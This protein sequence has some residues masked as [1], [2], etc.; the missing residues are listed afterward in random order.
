MGTEN[1]VRARRQT[2]DVGGRQ[3]KRTTRSGVSRGSRVKMIAAGVGSAAIIAVA[4]FSYLYSSS[5]HVAVV[6][7]DDYI[8]EVAGEVSDA[9]VN[10]LSESTVR[11]MIDKCVVEQ[12]NQEEISKII[13]NAIDGGM[14]ATEVDNLAETIQTHLSKMDMD[15]S[16]L[17]SDAQKNYINTQAYNIANDVLSG[18]TLN[19]SFSDSDYSALANKVQQLVVRNIDFEKILSEQGYYGGSSATTVQNLV[20]TPAFESAL[21]DAI[22]SATAGSGIGGTAAVNN[23]QL[24][25]IKNEILRTVQAG[26]KNGRDGADGRQGAQGAQGLTGAAGK[27][28]KDGVTPTK[29]VDYFTQAEIAS[30]ESAAATKAG[31]VVNTKIQNV[32]NQ[33]TTNESSL[34]NLV[35]QVTN[36][37]TDVTNVTNKVTSAG[38]TSSDDIN[39]L[40]QSISS[41]NSNINAIESNANS[42]KNSVRVKKTSLSV[43][44]ADGSEKIVDTTGMAMADFVDLLAGNNGTFTNV[45][46]TYGNQITTIQAAI[47]D[48]DEIRT[49]IKTASVNIS[50]LT[51]GQRQLL[52]D[53]QDLDG[54]SQTLADGI[55]DVKAK[56]TALEQ[57]IA[58]GDSEAIKN[59]KDSLVY[60][61]AKIDATD[62]DLSSLGLSDEQL[63]AYRQAQNIIK[64]MKDDIA[65]SRLDLDQS[66]SDLSN[67]GDKSDEQIK[68]I[69]GALSSNLSDDALAN[70][71]LDAETIAKLKEARDRVSA[72][73]EGME[74]NKNNITNFGDTLRDLMNN[75][76]KAEN[77]IKSV[78]A[79]LKAL[80]KWQQAVASGDPDAIAKAKAELEKVLDAI[81]SP[82]KEN[83][84]DAI[85]DWKNGVD[86]DGSGLKISLEME[87]S[88]IMDAL[89]KEI[90]ELKKAL[91]SDKDMEGIGIDPTD[92]VLKSVLAYLNGLDLDNST[93]LDGLHSGMN[94]IFGKMNNSV[95][96]KMQ[97]LQTDLLG[98]LDSNDKKFSKELADN[99]STINNSMDAILAKLQEND[100]A[101]QQK[102]QALEQEL[103]KTRN[104]IYDAMGVTKSDVEKNGTLIDR[105]KDA[106][107]MMEQETKAREDAIGVAGEDGETVYGNIK[108]I[109][110]RNQWA[111]NLI[112][113]TGG[114]STG[115]SV[116]H[117][118]GKYVWTI[119]GADLPEGNKLT[120][121]AAD[122]TNG[123]PESEVYISYASNTPA[124]CAEYQVT[125]GTLVIAVPDTSLAGSSGVKIDSIHVQNK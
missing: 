36:L 40:N 98:A 67:L 118:G 123:I 76:S 53:Y 117:T 78:D 113:N 37:K 100:A 124:F 44:Q 116:A 121:K 56:S 92:S 51:D 50:T 94:E 32:T 74:A 107:G 99:V 29:G 47:G 108:K 4:G 102:E 83:L 24:T 79:A 33:L 35:T 5:K 3:P 25:S 23:V 65:R 72:L 112:L 110:D 19:G 10:T 96:G 104:D 46:G 57:A 86:T 28:G 9:V 109:N 103:G 52:K 125:N 84:K 34:K 16:I 64:S 75:V 27:D 39:R 6:M 42:L 93:N 71:G 60:A 111:T 88:D 55:A 63:T 18:I 59:A 69:L 95:S 14:T 20:N 17:F 15:E 2:R 62:A 122:L 11:K 70:M 105:I 31:D 68:A 91:K 12:F 22:K 1:N 85:D 45:L 43:L 61:L 80:E 101:R 115:I 38:V 13:T 30:I 81:G 114:G 106:I 77:G 120:F 21:Q 48:I 66:I 7:A 119:T 90:E 41:I 8:Q 26:V 49:G 54:K 97:D 87:K 89:K 73:Q 58:S 82:Y